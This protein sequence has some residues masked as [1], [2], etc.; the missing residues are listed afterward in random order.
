MSITE[1]QQNLFLRMRHLQGLLY[2][3]LQC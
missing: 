1:G 2:T 3:T